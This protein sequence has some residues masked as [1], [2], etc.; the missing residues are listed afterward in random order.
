MV[1]KSKSRSSLTGTP[2][3]GSPSTGSSSSGTPRAPPQSSRGRDTPPSRPS[4]GGSTSHRRNASP[5]TPRNP[6]DSAS[7]RALDPLPPGFLQSFQSLRLGTTPSPQAGPVDAALE[8]EAAVVPASDRGVTRHRHVLRVAMGQAEAA[9]RKLVM[10]EMVAVRRWVGARREIPGVERRGR[11][12]ERAGRGE[13]DEGR[14]ADAKA[15]AGVVA[16][17]TAWISTQCKEGFVQL[18]TQFRQNAGL[19]LGAYVTV[20]SWPAPV[21]EA[22]RIV[23]RP[24]AADED[25]EVDEG[26]SMLMKEIMID[27]RHATLNACIEAVYQGKERQFRIE[28]AEPRRTPGAKDEAGETA[29][30]VVMEVTRSTEVVVVSHERKKIKAMAAT[31]QNVDYGTIGGLSKQV[32]EIR[33]IVEAPLLNPEK[34][35]KLGLRPPRGVLLYGPPGT[36]KT[37]VARVVAAETGAHVILVNGP[38]IISKY[39]GETEER[40]R[41]IFLEAE[42]NAPSIIFFDEID[43]LCPSRDESSS[44]LE[45]RVVTTMLTLMDGAHHK[46]RDRIADGVIVMA[47]T[48]RPQVIDEAL[49]RP[50]RFD[51]EIEIGIPDGPARLDILHKQLRNVPHTLTKTQIADVAARAHGYV[52]ADLAAVV[53]EAGMQVLQRKAAEEAVVAA[54][55]PRKTVD[56]AEKLWGG[57]ED[58][59]DGFDEETGMPKRPEELARWAGI[60]KGWEEPVAVEAEEVRWQSRIVQARFEKP[61]ELDVNDLRIGFDDMIDALAKIKPTSMREVM[62]EVPRVLWSDI[63]GQAEIKQRLQEAIEWP[64]KN[65]ELFAKYKIRPPK[66]ILLYGPPGCS[67]T[68]LAKALATE[69]GLNFLAVKGPEL[70]SKWVGDSEKAIRE[71][72]RKARAASPSIIFFDEIDAIAVRRGSGDTSVADRVL[73]QMLS[74]MDGVEPL[75]NVTVVAATN[76]PDILDSALLRPGRIDRILYVS[77]P[78]YDARVEILRIQTG[79][80]ACAPD[81]DIADLARK[82]E[83]YSG[84]EV[85]AICQEAAYKA[86]EEDANAKQVEHRHFLAGVEGVTPRI[87]AEVVAFYDRFKHRSGLRSI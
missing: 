73:A 12:R 31:D 44:D 43:S 55:S 39:Y 67:K 86:M 61:R 70:F 47:A 11:G 24:T 75:V 18:S 42:E 16:I 19:E 15:E 10:G 21:P 4:G 79:K 2:S 46:D 26:V 49:R 77:P 63:G 33:N 22:A 58:E 7:T 84:A 64:L 32:A 65:P 66:G 85:V 50:G 14:R 82:T 68:L 23:L 28:K 83:G 54:G 27:I 51:R 9:R 48:N 5:P 62:V 37:L 69:T 34:F 56:Y 38:D 72:F 36:G 57:R 13:E 74:E 45:K 53:R 3:R 41:S 17:G 35:I 20:A 60:G 52:G 40:L 30:P 71:V 25:F 80:M 81:V 78:D 1:K 76:R 59:E 6:P 87:T 8:V 29:G